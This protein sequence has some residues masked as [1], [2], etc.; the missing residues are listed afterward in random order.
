[1]IK[2]K[3]FIIICLC[4]TV[5][6]STA[7]TSQKILWQNKTFALFKDSIVQENRFVAK[8]IS[9][10]ELISDYKSPANE[11]LNPAI[12]FKFSI[13]GKDNEMTSGIDHHFNCISDDGAM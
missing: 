9:P 11:F 10:T 3:I 12:T 4:S 8:A 13:N 2:S 5:N 6:M 7:Q 1:M